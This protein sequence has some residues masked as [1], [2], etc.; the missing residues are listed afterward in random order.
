[1]QD[2]GV[3]GNG[4][5]VKPKSG[6]FGVVASTLACTDAVADYA[7]EETHPRET[8]KK[9][10]EHQCLDCP[11]AALPPPVPDTPSSMQVRAIFACQWDLPAAESRLWTKKVGVRVWAWE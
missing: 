10:P 4:R 9:K 6:C 7:G 1:M 11:N 3:T 8:V 2:G 5:Q